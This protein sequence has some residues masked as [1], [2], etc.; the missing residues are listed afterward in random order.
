MIATIFN[1]AA[2]ANQYLSPS[3]LHF[4]TGIQSHLRKSMK[5]KKRSKEYFV[6]IRNLA[7]LPD[8]IY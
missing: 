7:F 4:V 6:F 5:C 3:H 1:H 2:N 8:V